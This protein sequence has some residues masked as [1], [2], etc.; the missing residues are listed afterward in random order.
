MDTVR[1]LRN[2]EKSTDLGFM[3]QPAE[4]FV[5]VIIDIFLWEF[6]EELTEI[7]LLGQ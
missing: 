1:F 6:P 2:S 3:F 4:K 7:D 5:D